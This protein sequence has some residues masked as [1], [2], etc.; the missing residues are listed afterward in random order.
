MEGKPQRPII[1]AGSGMKQTPAAAAI[2][3][4]EA[5]GPVEFTRQMKDD[6]RALIVFTTPAGR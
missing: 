2:S 3:E 4:P 5:Y 1:E 6:G